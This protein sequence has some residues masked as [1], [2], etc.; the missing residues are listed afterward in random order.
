MTMDRLILGDNPFFGINHMSEE[1]A[2]LQSER[3]SDTAS[4]LK[5]IDAAYD[6]GIRGFMFTTHDRVKPLC[7]HFRAHPDRYRDMNLYPALPYAH[8][9]ATAV[10]EKGILGAVKDA[11]SSGQG[12]GRTMSNILR[13]G[14]GFAT[15]DMIP[16]MKL[17]V[18]MELSMFR[19][20]N[21]KVVFLQNV[22][23]DLLLGLKLGAAFTNFSDH[24]RQ[25]HYAEAG[26]ITMNLPALSDYLLQIGMSKPIICASVNKIGHLMNPDRESYERAIESR[27]FR[28]VAMSLLA[29]G[30]ISPKEAVDYALGLKPIESI[31]FGASST[32]HIEEMQRLVLG[33]D[34]SAYEKAPQLVSYAN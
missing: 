22:V 29:S 1:K 17:L 5:V 3:F 18:D 27:R 11:L 26:F 23:T 10:A 12:M 21:V 9:Y 32:S 25:N 16:A 34:R 31:V 24:I 20:L 13:S 14:V 4:I 19:G 33:G 30:A 6:R 7:D 8:K 28:P 2:Q 15:Q